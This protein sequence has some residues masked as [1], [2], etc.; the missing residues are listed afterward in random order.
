LILSA[1]L[2]IALSAQAEDNQQK[3]VILT[4]EQKMLIK[5]L[6]ERQ[7]IEQNNID[8]EVAIDNN[9][10]LDNIDRANSYILEPPKLEPI[11]RIT[12]DTL[13]NQLT[14][15]PLINVYPNQITIFT[16]T[17]SMGKAWPLKSNPIIGAKSYYHVNY[18]HNIP[19]VVT[20]ET[21]ARYVPTSMAVTLEDRV[22]PIQFQLRSNGHKLNGDVR[23]KIIGKSR[24]N[25]STTVTDSYTIPTLNNSEATEF[26]GS[27]P[28]D[29]E[30]VRVLGD[31]ATS[32]WSWRNRCYVR[33][34]HQITNPQK[35]IDIQSQP[36]A[37]N[38]IYVFNSLPGAIAVFNDQSGEVKSIRIVGGCL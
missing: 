12:V 8:P 21:T 22:Q 24:L 7:A 38:K 32:V 36:D 18:D 23:V 20:V 11:K 26:L 3:R 17:D 4:D 16:F 27:P 1:I 29:S 31:A 34:P 15:Q 28:D 2:L 35:P 5:K 30:R 33:T 25:K 13:G 19:G 37:N 6:A 10:A 9:Q 14:S